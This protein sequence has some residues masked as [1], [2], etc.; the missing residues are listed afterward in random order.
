MKIY[1]HEEGQNKMRTTND[2]DH[3]FNND[4]EQLK[5]CERNHRKCWNVE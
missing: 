5:V 3:N 1:R 4:E 2:K